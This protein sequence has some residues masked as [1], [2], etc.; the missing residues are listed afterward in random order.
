MNYQEF[1]NQVFKTA[2]NIVDD[3]NCTKFKL[4]G[5]K[6]FDQKLILYFDDCNMV[7]E[8]RLVEDRIEISHFYTKNFTHDE[9]LEE[10]NLFTAEY[11]RDVDEKLLTSEINE[12]SV[13]K[14]KGVY[15]LEVKDNAYMSPLNNKKVV[16][17]EYP[18][19]K[20][21]NY[22]QPENFAV[23]KLVDG[24]LQMIVEIKSLKQIV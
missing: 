16:V 10:A 3:S 9:H 7:Y 24:G 11:D 17:L 5:Y 4:M 18:L 20:K 8:F 2:C 21:Y 19:N 22:Q 13:I 23:V 14:I 6:H 12:D 15:T 1:R